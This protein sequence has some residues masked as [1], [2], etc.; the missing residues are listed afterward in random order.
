M[1]GTA[2]ASVH[3]NFFALGGNSITGAVLINRLQDD[4]G[5]IVHVVVIFDAPTVADLA[6]YLGREHAGAVARRFGV[7]AAAEAAEAAE[8]V[9]APHVALA[10]AAG[11][12]GRVDAAPKNLPAI[13]V[14]SPPRSGTTLLRVMLAGHPGLF[15][16]PEL[17]LLTFDTMAERRAA[18]TGRDSF[19][20]EGAIRAV[21]AAR[22]LDAARAAALVEDAERQGWET[23]RFYGQL[24]SWL[25]ERRLVDKT[26][27]Y[28][29]DPAVLARAEEVFAEPFYIHL[30]RHPYG[31]IH[32]FEEAKLDQLFFRYPHRF[33]RRE[34]AELIWTVSHQNVLELLAGVPARRQHRVIYEEL[35]A[36]PERI[37]LGLCA[38]LGI[39]FHPDMAQPYKEGARRMT[40]GIHKESRMLG[41]VKFH[42]HTGVDPASAW[43][44]RQSYAEDFLG[45]VTWSLAVRLLLPAPP[46]SASVQVPAAERPVAP[47]QALDVE[48]PAAVAP[49]LDAGKPA[50]VAKALDAGSPTAA[51][52]TSA[53]DAASA[54]LALRAEPE[55]PG[56]PLP[57]SFAQE[58]L[59]FLDQLY[60]SSAAYNIPSAMRLNGQLQPAPL[61]QALG[62]VMRR[63]SVLRARFF[64]EGGTPAQVIAEA[65]PA[66]LPRI[67][68]SALPE[69]SRHAEQRRLTATEAARPFDLGS[70]PLLRGALMRLT[71]ANH[72][73]LLILHHIVGDGWSTGVLIRELAALYEAFSRGLPSPLPEP[74]IQ[75]ADFARWQRG[76]LSGET[77]DRQLAFWR[78]ALAG[79]AALQLPT[80][81][82][83]PAV[84]T[85]RGA[86]R[87]LRVGSAAVG[88]LLDLGQR[89]GA[90]PFMSL[91][92][93]FAVLLSRYTGQTDI[94]VGTPS[95]NRVR[96]EL[97]GLIG[98]FVNTLVL[99]TNLAG[100]VSFMELLARVRQASLAAFA[101]QD[102]PFEKIVFELQPERD[103]SRSPLFQVMFAMQDGFRS[104][105]ELPG[106]SL[107]NLPAN[108]G[109]AKFDLSLSLSTG[110]HGLACTLEHKL[111]LFE[112]ATAERLL[113]HFTALL[114]AAAADPLRPVDELPLLDGAERQQLL[115]EGSGSAASFPW[116]GRADEL[117]ARQ[118]ARHPQEVAVTTRTEERTYGELL[119][120]AARVAA[121]LRSLGIGRGEAVAVTM[122]RSVR[123][124]EALLGVWQAG[125]AY[126]PMDPAYP[127]E[128]LV[129]MLEDAGCRVL[130]ADQETPRELVERAAEVV[131]VKAGHPQAEAPDA[132][133]A[134]AAPQG[135]PLDLAYVLYTSGSTG[136]P[137]GVEVP[138]GALVNFLLSM[139]ERPGLAAGDTSRPWSCTCRCSPGRGSSWWSA[140]WRRTARGCWSAWK[141]PARPCCR[142]RRRAGGCW[143]SR[144]GRGA[145]GSRRCAAARRCPR[146]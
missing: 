50:A 82:P 67:D 7:A 142:R 76:W 9:K 122:G 138:H 145:R 104:R 117:I 4:L 41:D 58:R 15:A 21:M 141:G 59:W 61:A 69:P 65:A 112:G 2:P 123:L 43:H 23:A 144:G 116:E 79:V 64:S 18:F 120:G 37:L 100:G 36:A 115:I 99:R 52:S 110:S 31:M 105:I 47:A 94:A 13:F 114:A 49:M 78:Q 81:H 6:A 10:A 46:P 54:W 80:D 103:L 75:Y 28:A 40:D 111:D 93:A 17:E 38:A 71:P 101:H 56:V 44:W 22:G 5:E 109:V 29:L 11:S 51:S 8:A 20:L 132:A 24:Q 136:R 95:A 63:H 90:T 73:M 134:R 133:V 131:W 139:A 137:K 30:V 53:A 135:D 121:R 26:P 118:A 83:R 98:F 32:S 42:R 84:E 92:A 72:V 128:R 140:T 35:V 27:S 124:V 62:E 57:L 66:A 16:P 107:E 85:F 39:A 74:A 25:G 126:V 60:P 119:A 45:D 87:K 19:W 89:R 130:L 68:L 86:R 14:L 108:P 97:E 102:L 91:L 127:V 113:R 146:G 33:G 34:L 1:L 55:R 129:Y 12:N 106:L 48:R 88:P 70:G 143:W 3:D 125:G 96:A 77:L